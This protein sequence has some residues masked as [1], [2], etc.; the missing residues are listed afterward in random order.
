[1]RAL[2]FSE[3]GAPS[4]LSLVEMRDPEPDAATVVVRVVASSVNPSDV[5]NVAG[6]M[7]G[8]V[9]PRVPGRDFSGI[10]EAGPPEW[11]G[12]EVWGTG[13]DIGF[14]QDGAHAERL[15]FPT[16]G[17][18]RKPR[19]LTHGVTAA[20][21]LTFVVA[22]LGAIDYAAARPGETVAVIGAGGGV[23]GAVIQIVKAL[24]CRV[25][26][27]DRAERPLPPAG[28]LIDEFVSAASDV[29]AEVKRLTGGQGAD[30]IFDTVGGVMFE[31]ALLSLRRRGRLVE[32]SGTGRRRVAFDLIDFYH[33]ESRI[34]GAD[35][36]KLDPV[37]SA[38]ILAA[39]VPG[40]EAG[41]LRPPAIAR[42][43]SLADGVAAYEAVATGTRG[44]VVIAP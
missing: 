12:A 19:N 16:A 13:G 6:L 40:F 11:L 44:R 3:F 38:K 39:L 34:F 4:K 41:R 27:V 37:D 21:G 9:L 28:G 36:R 2:R 23:G 30:L 14:S 42:T 17:L 26:A 25:I 29:P 24:G 8:T 31:S 22:W 20:I 32:I 7:E 5:K 33:N 18:V 10:V 43:S 1:M 35:T 15:A